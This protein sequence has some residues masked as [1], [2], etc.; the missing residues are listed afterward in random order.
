PVRTVTG[1]DVRATADA[2]GF[3]LV[4]ADNSFSLRLRGDVQVDGRFISDNPSPGTQSF[5]VRR[6][7]LVFQGTLHSRFAFKIMPNFGMGRAELQDAYMDAVFTPSFGVRAGKFK[8]P[9]GIELL[10]SPTTM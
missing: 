7:R 3:Q 6:T 10:Q 1:Q 4:A 2:D 5:Y 8:V 9:V